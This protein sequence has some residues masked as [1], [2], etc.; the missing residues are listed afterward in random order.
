MTESVGISL[1]DFSKATPDVS[2]S[3]PAPERL[4]AGTPVHVARNFFS[5]KTGQ[6]FAGIWESS[7]G[8]WRVSYTENEF[9]HITRGKVRI[10]DALGRSWT[11][12][13]GDSFVV[14]AGFTGVWEVLEPASKLYVIF[15]AAIK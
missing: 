2:E 10:E 14:P 4:L 1:V 13:V 6:F 9:C 12:K 7:P 8:K 11:F 3:R 15:E 5:D